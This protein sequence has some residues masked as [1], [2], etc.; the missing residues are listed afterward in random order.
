[1]N[2]TNGKHMPTGGDTLIMIA[3]EE[4]MLITFEVIIANMIIIKKKIVYYL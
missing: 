1:M 3:G 2:A 4:R